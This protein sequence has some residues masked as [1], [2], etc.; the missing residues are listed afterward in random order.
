MNSRRPPA[1]PMWLLDRL[2]YT[3]QNAPLA[4][5]LVEEF[6]SGRSPGWFWRQTFMVMANGV[7]RNAVVLRPYL[8]AICAGFAASLVLM[9]ELARLDALPRFHSI[10]WRAIQLVTAFSS[11]CAV[12]AVKLRSFGGAN[13]NLRSLAATTAA[14]FGR[15]NVLVPFAFLETLTL[16]LTSYCIVALPFRSPPSADVMLRSLAICF[17][18]DVVVSLARAPHNGQWPDQDMSLP[19]KLADGRV[20]VLRP[21]TLAESAFAAGE[22]SLARALFQCGASIEVLRRAVWNGC[23]RNYCARQ[24]DPALPPITVSDLAALV[25][26][27]QNRITGDRN[28]RNR[29]S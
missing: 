11:Y 5:D 4:G 18:L 27:A 20:L 3:R 2:G 12:L 23:A 28:R 7:R 22:E 29:P 17:A 6:Q 19:V 8:L 21:E 14:H 13:V 16:W 26:E 24:I 15:W 25:E 1:L 10:G 9:S